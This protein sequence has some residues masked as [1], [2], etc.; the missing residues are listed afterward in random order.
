VKAEG[1][2]TTLSW[3]VKNVSPFEHEPGSAKE[4]VPRVQISPTY[5]EM[6]DYP[7]NMSSWNSFGK[8]GLSLNDKINKIPEKKYSLLPRPGEECENRPRKNR[9]PL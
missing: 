1:N 9:D 7:G 2:L 8:W 4:D 3:E 5:F 6:D